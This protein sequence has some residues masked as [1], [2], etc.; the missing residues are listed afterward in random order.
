MTD[1]LTNSTDLGAVADA[2]RA[3]GGTSAQLVY[4]SGFVTAIQNI[5]SGGSITVAT[6]TASSTQRNIT[7]A[8]VSEYP[9]FFVVQNTSGI[10]P[11]SSGVPFAVFVSAQKSGASSYGSPV[12][13]FY[14]GNNGTVAPGAASLFRDAYVSS[15]SF[16][17]RLNNSYFYG[18]YTITYVY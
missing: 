7:F 11:S 2:I 14:T 4:P 18:D 12:M 1:Y 17:V 6:A 3:K 9:E 13:A 16:T 5:P 10:A 8:G 15:G